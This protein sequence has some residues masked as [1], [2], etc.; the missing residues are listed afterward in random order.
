MNMKIIIIYTLMLFGLDAMATDDWFCKD[1]SGRREG[2]TIQACGVGEGLTESEARQ[3]SLSNALHEFHELCDIS[4]D[5]A[6]HDLRVTPERMTCGQEKVPSFI[7]GYLWKCY[8]M[9]QVTIR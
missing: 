5:C 4:S 6:E 2:K 3:L 1:G 7:H 8:R 9:I